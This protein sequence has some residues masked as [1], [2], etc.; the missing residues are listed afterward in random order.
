MQIQTQT[1]KQSKDKIRIH[2]LLTTQ[3]NCMTSCAWH[4]CG[5]R[6]FP[7]LAGPTGTSV[8]II[9]PT[10]LPKW[11]CVQLV[12]KLVGKMV[13]KMSHRFMCLKNPHIP[14]NK[15]SCKLPDLLHTALLH[16]AD[17]SNCVRPTALPSIRMVAVELTPDRLSVYIDAGQPSYR[18][19][20]E[21][22]PRWVARRDKFVRLLHQFHA[23]EHAGGVRRRT[24][25]KAKRSRTAHT[26][27]RTPNYAAE[28]YL[29]EAA[30]C[31]LATAW[32]P[33]P[34]Y[35]HGRSQDQRHHW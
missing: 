34:S 6:G 13:G 21:Q 11:H 24:K 33:V 31:V 3:Y 27:D 1:G 10:P 20:A 16:Q 18:A 9:R 7:Y 30:G 15:N 22:P 14:V 19:S 23:T 26:D 12:G 17:G 8:S 5:L 4:Y 29:T 35:P 25:E 28:I 2:E 32:Q